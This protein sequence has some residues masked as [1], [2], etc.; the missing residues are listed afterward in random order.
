MTSFASPHKN[1]SSSQQVFDEGTLAKFGVTRGGSVP[2]VVD[3]KLRRFGKE[4]PDL[5]EPARS[6]AERL[7]WSANQTRRDILYAV[8][9]AAKYSAAPKLLH[10]HR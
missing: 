6:L 9:A 2:A 3:R 4:K 8:R 10:W 1:Y 5:D 7:L